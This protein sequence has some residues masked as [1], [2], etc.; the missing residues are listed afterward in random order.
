MGSTWSS[1]DEVG[2]AWYLECNSCHGC[3]RGKDSPSVSPVVCG[4]G[5]LDRRERIGWRAVQRPPGVPPM[6]PHR[7]LPSL[8]L[9][10]LILVAC[11]EGNEA[12][13]ESSQIAPEGPNVIADESAVDES[14]DVLPRGLTGRSCW[15]LDGDGVAEVDEDVNQDGSFDAQDCRGAAGEPG[16][17]GQEGT[18]GQPGAAGLTGAT[19]AP[20]PR[21]P[22]GIE[23]LP[24][25]HVLARKLSWEELGPSA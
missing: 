11:S 18:P 19:G 15:D 23:G 14:D 20:G 25:D 3:G 9:T 13:R 5:C 8:V 10:L 17:S 12:P 4:R 16:A 1:L 7:T 24:G 22:A 2:G 6:S 21:G